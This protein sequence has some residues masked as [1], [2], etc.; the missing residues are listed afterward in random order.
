MREAARVTSLEALA[1]FRAA[2]AEF[3]EQAKLALA[4]AESDVQRT[5]WW[6]QNELKKHWQLQIRKRQQ[7]MAL[8]KS[9]LYRAEL[10]SRDERPSCVLERRAYEKAMRQLQEAEE[11]VRATEMWG[12][13]LEQDLML[14]KGHVQGLS[15]RLDRD[16]PQGLARLATSIDRLEAYIRTSPPDTAPRSPA[17]EPDSPP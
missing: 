5:M 7:A 2:Y 17:P 9:E 3:Q 14:Y 16:V 8:A 11:K 6:L 10:A 15:S 13:R 1:R 4:N 12:R